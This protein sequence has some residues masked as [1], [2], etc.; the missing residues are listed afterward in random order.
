MSCLEWSGHAKLGRCE[1]YGAPRKYEA[2]S[3]MSETNPN[4]VKAIIPQT[5]FTLRGSHVYLLRWGGS[6]LLSSDKQNQCF[7]LIFTTLTFKNG[8]FVRCFFANRPPVQVK[9]CFHTHFSLSPL[10]APSGSF[11][12]SFGP[13]W[14]PFGSPLGPLWVPCRPPSRLPGPFASPFRSEIEHSGHLIAS[15]GSE[16]ELSL[17]F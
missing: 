17:C 10:W 9:P 3:R 8:L 12:P 1:R 7:S 2:R 5:A 13:L 4:F 16:M 6:P 14:V 15:F 11:W